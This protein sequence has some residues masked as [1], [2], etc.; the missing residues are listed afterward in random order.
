MS[1]PNPEQMPDA[2]L[3]LTQLAASYAYVP[4]ETVEGAE[5][6][7]AIALPRAAV[8]QDQQGSFVFVVGE[9][10]VATRRNVTLGRSSAETAVIEGGL[11]GGETV[12]VEGLQRVR[13]GQPV[14][15]GPASGPTVPQT[16]PG[17]G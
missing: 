3:V 16:V 13:P 10:N 8:L 2:E 7:M 14:N 11:N 9:N 4:Q 6:V 5:P 1:E 15:P 17:R 12:V